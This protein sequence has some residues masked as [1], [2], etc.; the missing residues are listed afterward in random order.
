MVTAI[1]MVTP[2]G[3]GVE[4]T[5]RGV[6][7]GAN[8]VRPIGR[9][10]ATDYPVRFAAEVPVEGSG[11]PLK[12]TLAL[13]ALDEAV[14]NIA[15]TCRPPAPGPRLGVCLG[16]EAARPPLEWLFRGTTPAVE[17]IAALAPHA[18]TRTIADRVGALGP[19]STV[20]TA[21]T[22]S[23]QAIGEAVLRIRRGEVDAMIAGGVD[24]LSEPLMVVGF[25]KL[26]AL[27]TRNDAPERASRPFDLHR[28][29]FVL[30]EGAGMLILEE[31]ESAMARG[32][33]ILA[34]VSGY[35]CSC[36][37]WRITD[38]PP[39]GRGAA[40]A[41]LEA[42]TD[43]GL[44]PADIGYINA[45]GTSTP[46]N[47]QSES[48]AIH[49]VFGSAEAGGTAVPVSSTKGQMGH[50][51]AACGAVEA[52]LCILALRDQIL[53]PTRNLI[54]PDPAC[55]PLDHILVARP[56]HGTLRH[57][58]TNAFG[59]GGSNGSLVFSVAE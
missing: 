27:S 24:V 36:N 14:S 55:G 32:A 16:S 54:T 45:H 18:P 51:V 38:S 22:S 48:Q 56:T 37:A 31:R 53:P 3:V 2:L 17:D 34:E 10:D 46:Q 23:S 59:F 42:I 9:F 4:A 25:A 58:L 30:G 20:A 35:G 43:A 52:I 40:A 29:G 33:P 12:Q 8:G 49:R 7:A 1:G 5:W 44:V 26:G 6:L 21:C 47:D 50:L 39:D 28:D 11:A 57:T 13:L 15:Q 19:R 41:M